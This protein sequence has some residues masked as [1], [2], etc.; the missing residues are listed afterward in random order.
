MPNYAHL[1]VDLKCPQCNTLF[2]D[3]F[4]FQWGYCPARIPID[5]HFYHIGDAIRWRVCTDGSAPAWTYF[6]DEVPPSANIGDP[7]IQNVLIQDSELSWNSTQPTRCSVCNWLLGGAM[8]E[9]RG[10][11]IKRAW[12]YPPDEFGQFVNTY[13]IAENG[14]LIPKPDWNDHAMHSLQYCSSN[15]R[16]VTFAVSSQ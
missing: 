3:L 13:L 4:W 8:L 9:V 11:I 14:S 7:S 16:L 12:L 10:G 5:T 1:A 6:N 15:Q 2:Y